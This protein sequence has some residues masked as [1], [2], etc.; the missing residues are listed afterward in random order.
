MGNKPQNIFFLVFVGTIVLLSIWGPEALSRY[1]DQRL[2]YTVRQ[3]E[4]DAAE[5]GFR[6]ELTASEKLFI[7]S[8]AVSSQNLPES[9]QSA[10]TRPQSQEEYPEFTGTYAFIVNHQGPSGKELTEEA[11]Y[12]SCNEQLSLLKQE[13]ILP[14][15]VLTVEPEWY[16][17]VLY[18]AID[19]YEP[20]NNVS[21][22][23][24]S[25]STGLHNVNKENRLTDAYIDAG[26]G[27]IIEFYVRT[28]C[29]WAEL[30][31]DQMIQAWSR[32]MELPLPEPAEEPNP[33]RETASRYKK[34]AFPA[35]EDEYTVV[36]VGFYDGIRELFIAAGSRR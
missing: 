4:V 26:S 19:T 16:D 14:E 5:E 31:P 7:F 32:Y 2:F 17:A 22:W 20:R 21:V 12:A 8:R 29:S 36:T 10:I 11:L 27:K 24:L 3:Q 6:Y 1:Y 28:D 13:G 35:S 34:Y 18:S 9:E 25:L 15:S 30:S 33:L 23:K